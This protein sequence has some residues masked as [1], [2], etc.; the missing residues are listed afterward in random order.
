MLGVATLIVVNSVM[1]GFST[2]LRDRLHGLLSDVVIES[3][4]HDGFSDPEG[5]MALIRSDPFLRDQIEVMTPTVEVFALLQFH[6]NGV[7]F[8]RVVHLIGIDPEGR[9]RLGG[10]AEYLHREENRQHPSFDPP[11]EALRR[12][13]EV[14]RGNAENARAEGQGRQGT[15]PRGRGAA[16]RGGAR[17]AGRRRGRGAAAGPGRRGGGGG[18]PPGAGAGG[19]RRVAPG[20]PAG[21]GGGGGARPRAGRPPAGV[22]RARRAGRTCR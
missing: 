14:R 4:D 15:M 17:T 5:K 21:G 1:A 18:G 19:A 6:Y 16:P 8:L 20:P 3:W 9:A 10:F 22:R 11:P 12:I 13:E 7:P 2:K